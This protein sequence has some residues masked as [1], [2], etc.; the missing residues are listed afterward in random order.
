M[1]M[2]LQI[3]FRH[4]E[5][6]PAVEERARQLAHELEQFSSSILRC[7]VTIDC[8]H[9][10]QTQGRKFEVHL[11]IVVPDKHITVSRS[12]PAS[13]DHEDVYVAL[14]DAFDAATR[15]L[16]EYERIRRRDVKAHSAPSV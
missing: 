12:H 7:R 16:Q 8:P 14:R 2:P 5:P 1:Q 10:H 6:S 3:A 13:D 11:E 15:Q 9:K 4:L